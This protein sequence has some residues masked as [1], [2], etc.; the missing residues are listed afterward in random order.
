MED[1]IPWTVGPSCEEPRGRGSRLACPPTPGGGRQGRCTARTPRSG[2]PGS[3]AGWVPHR[4]ARCAGTAAPSRR[5]RDQGTGAGHG[6]L[7]EG[8]ELLGAAGLA[9]AST[10]RTSRPQRRPGARAT[11]PASSTRRR[12]RPQA[13]R[14]Q[15]RALPCQGRPLVLQKARER[16][17]VS[18]AARGGSGRPCSSTSVTGVEPTGAAS[19]SSA[20]VRPYYLDGR[21]ARIV[22]VIGFQ[23]SDRRSAGF[24]D[25]A[26]PR[27]PPRSLPVSR[28]PARDG[29]TPL[30][31][32]RSVPFLLQALQNL[33]TS[34][35][36]CCDRCSYI[37]R[38]AF[39]SDR[40]PG[41]V[42]TRPRSRTARRGSG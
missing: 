19:E 20:V 14:V 25:A 17:A 28:L 34:L 15:P 32:Q 33:Y 30:Q 7:P 3:I 1:G 38:G 42:R 6:V 40:R 5:L 24:D 12:R 8:L 39:V 2:G 23:P 21:S 18:S 26:Q 27:R 29:P 9:R 31:R 37:W 36:R 4:R 11:R 41:R 10:G 22:A 35:G 16:V 13:G